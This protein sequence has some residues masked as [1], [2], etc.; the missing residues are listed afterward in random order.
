VGPILADS[1]CKFIAPVTFPDRLRIGVRVNEISPRGDR[2]QM[3]YLIESERLG[4]PVAVG[5]TVV[6]SLNY[7]TGAKCDLP[8]KWLT[9]IETIEGELPTAS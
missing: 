9:H 7:E 8:E 5:T 1:Y 2:F 3:E 4:R 6:V